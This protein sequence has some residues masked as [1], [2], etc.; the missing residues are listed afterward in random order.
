MAHDVPADEP[1][2]GG[3]ERVHRAEIPGPIDDDRV[4]GI[5]E[6][7]REQIEPLLRAREHQDVFR[8]AA[9][10]LRDRFAQHR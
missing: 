4:A 5:D 10:P 8:L 7:A 6:A 3:A 2:A 9:E 1:R